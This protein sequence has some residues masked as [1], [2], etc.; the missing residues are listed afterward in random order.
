MKHQLEIEK[1]FIVKI[2]KDELKL[3]KFL[4]SL[5]DVLYIEQIYLQKE[6][7][8]DSQSAR[9]RKTVSLL[10][11]STSLE[12]NKKKKI[13]KNVSKEKEGEI[14]NKELLNLLKK[15][16]PEQSVLIKKR[17]VFKYKNQ[18]FELDKFIEPNH[19]KGLFILEIE[20]DN[21][22]EKVNFP[23]FL[24][25]VKEVTEDKNYN[26]YFLAKK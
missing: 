10:N 11:G 13:E 16:D 9:V 12:Y 18:T 20:L 19:L 2:P 26:N 22:N 21:K 24:D 23:P 3:K 7:P 5:E 25:I 15:A 1:K 17:F 4:D 8:K 14:S 6:N